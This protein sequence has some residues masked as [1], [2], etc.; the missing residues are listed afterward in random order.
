MPLKQRGFLPQEINK[1]WD[2]WKAGQTL[3]DIGRDLRR[4]PGSIFHIVAANGGIIPAKRAKKSSDLTLFEREE[5]SRGLAV[6]QSIRQIALGLGRS[7]STVSREVKRNGGRHKYRAFHADARAWDMSKRPKDCKLEVNKEL[8]TLVEER[9]L[10]NWSPE[11]VSGWLKKKYLEECN[12]WLS[13]E[14]IYKSLFIQSKGLLNKELRKHLRTKRLMRRPKNAKIDRQ[15]R[16]Q[17]IDLVSIRERPAEAEDRAIPGHWEGDLISGSNN[18][19]IATL[20]ERSSRFTI[21]VKVKG[22][23]TESVVS[24]IQHKIMALPKSLRISLTWDRGMELASHKKLSLA[25]NISVYFC[26]PR[27]P[28]QRGTNENTNRLL[29]QYFPKK[30]DLSIYSQGFLDSVAK[31]LNER[32]RKTLSFNTPADTLQKV[33]H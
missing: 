28:W 31:E 3:S 21:L 26:D 15:P 27:S 6:N 20:V 13:H 32:P 2:L 23:D 22:K 19:H 11:Q 4:N 5:I 12:M 25:T 24:A 33:L 16:G 17:I 30:T 9:L 7:P 18:T 8:K 29:R 10:L 1:I 14:T